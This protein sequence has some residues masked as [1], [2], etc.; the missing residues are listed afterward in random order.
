MRNTH[1]IL[2]QGKL[3]RRQWDG[4]TSALDVVCGRIEGEVGDAQQ[5]LERHRRSSRKRTQSREQFAHRKWLG[6][7][8]VCTRIESAD[9]IVYRIACR[10]H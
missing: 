4:D 3:A 5:R 6:Q 10:E 2:E 7:V 9:S 8:I 1:Q